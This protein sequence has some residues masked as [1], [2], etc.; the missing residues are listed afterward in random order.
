[1]MANET[2]NEV[3]AAAE[4]PAKVVEAIAETAETAV[5]QTAKAVKTDAKAPRTRKS[6]KPAER[7]VAKVKKVNARRVNKARRPAPRK[8]AAPQF[9][10][11]NTVTNDL[12][13]LF[14]FDALPGADKFQTLFADAG[15][16]G[17]EIVR[18][19]QK[20]A[21]EIAE[22]AKANVEALAEAGRIATAGASATTF[23]SA[24][25]TPSA[26]AARLIRK[27]PSADHGVSSNSSDGRRK[28]P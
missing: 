4:A 16:R 9:E 28:K 5:E 17:Q 2:K 12:N 27:P 25:I 7:V 24:D 22:L 6:R 15:E 18:K 14:A 10:R 3:Q 20:A 1:M 21:E 11:I 23:R 19:S 8:A 26:A 13:K